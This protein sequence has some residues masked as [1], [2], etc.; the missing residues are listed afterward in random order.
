MKTCCKQ[1]LNTVDELAHA[2]AKNV[3]ECI[4][5]M[6]SPHDKTS[7]N[8]ANFLCNNTIQNTKYGYILKELIASAQC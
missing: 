1:G 8:K 6:C 2:K 4:W 3:T 7:K 5:I